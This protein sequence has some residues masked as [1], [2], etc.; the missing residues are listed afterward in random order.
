MTRNVVIP[1]R[2]LISSQI[3]ELKKVYE[4]GINDVV[5]FRV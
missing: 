2:S 5:V 4:V 3:F 1:I